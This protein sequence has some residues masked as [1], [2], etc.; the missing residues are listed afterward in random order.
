M[1]SS[2]YRRSSSYPIFEMQDEKKRKEADDRRS[3]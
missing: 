3:K 1:S 2:T